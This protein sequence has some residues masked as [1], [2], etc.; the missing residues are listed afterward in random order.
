MITKAW[1]YPNGTIE[2]GIVTLRGPA[3]LVRANQDGTWQ[4]D[5]SGDPPK[6]WTPTAKF[7]PGHPWIK[8]ACEHIAEA[9]VHHRKGEGR[10]EQLTAEAKHS[11]EVKKQYDEEMKIRREKDDTPMA[12]L[13]P[14]RKITFDK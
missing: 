6:I 10:R 11:A 3:N 2:F 5:C 13:R 4:C 1:R 12:E 7:G 14:R 9:F 8:P